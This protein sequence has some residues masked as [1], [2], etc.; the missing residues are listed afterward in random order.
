MTLYWAHWGPLL[1]YRNGF[2]EIEDLN[3]DL[4]TR[5]RMSRWEM[6]RTGLRFMIAAISG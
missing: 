3:P 4:K 6:L 2:L 1:Q 5:W